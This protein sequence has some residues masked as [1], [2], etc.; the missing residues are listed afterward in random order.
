MRTKGEL[1]CEPSHTGQ[2]TYFRARDTTTWS[3]SYIGVTMGKIYSISQVSVSL[4]HGIKTNVDKLDG[5]GQVIHGTNLALGFTI[6]TS[7]A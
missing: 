4:I 5:Q 1:P 6:C 2:A 3:L 7:M